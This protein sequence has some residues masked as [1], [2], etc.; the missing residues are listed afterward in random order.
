MHVPTYS[1][2]L[3]GRSRPVQDFAFFGMW[4]DRTDIGDSVEFVNG[5]RRDLRG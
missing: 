2:Q 1:E 5:I 4:K 3:K